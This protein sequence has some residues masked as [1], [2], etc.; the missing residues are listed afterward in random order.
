[1]E[2]IGAYI[3][4]ETI[5]VNGPSSV[6]LARHAKLG[7]KTFLKVYTGEDKTVIERFEREAKIVADLNSASIV[8]IYDF[9]E[10]N[11]N[12][13]I[14][15][16][17]VPGQ[18]LA[19]FLKQ[20]VPQPERILDIALQISRAVSVLH[21]KGYIHRDLKPE[22]ILISHSGQIRLTDFGITLHESLN[23]VTSKGALLGTPLYMSPE[24]INNLELTPASDVFALGIIFYQLATGIN[25]FEAPQYAQVFSKILTFQPEPAQTLNPDLPEWFSRLIDSL[26][27]KNPQKRVAS[28]SDILTRFQD[29]GFEATESNQALNQ[30]APASTAAKSYFPF[31]M[32]ILI[33]VVAGIVWYLFQSSPSAEGTQPMGAVDSTQDTATI[34]R[35]DTAS[36]TPTKN[37][38]SQSGNHSK[39]PSASQPVQKTDAPT[40]P[41]RLLVKTYPWCNVYLNYTLIDKTPMQKAVNIEPGKHLLG[42]QNPNYPSYSDSIFIKPNRLNEITINLDSIFT[43]L[44]VQVIPW[45]KIYIDGKY[46]GTSPLQRPLYVTKETHWIE[47]KNRYYTSWVDSVDARFLPVIQ[48]AVVLKEK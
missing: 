45:G 8:Q 33:A 43:R 15:M 16:E 47:I 46:M 37:N 31:L 35:K 17:Y 18:N 21:E 23:R 5:S 41:T 30:P 29:Q 39:T 44:E 12:F 27:E 26:L 9:G 20:G 13:F 10:A 32:L 38:A 48:L 25:P 4:E 7:R 2:K 3:I 22:N 40:L 28:A 11:G 36:A 6:F 19:E 14:S 24:Q 34:V 1:M 42:L